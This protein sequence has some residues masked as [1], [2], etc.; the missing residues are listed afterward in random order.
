MNINQYLIV[1]RNLIFFCFTLLL[2]ITSCDKQEDFTPKIPTGENTACFYVDGVFNVPEGR[3]D[4]P[5]PSLKPIKFFGCEAPNKELAMV[6]HGITFNFSISLLDGFSTVGVFNLSQGNSICN[7]D[8]NGVYFESPDKNGIWG[9]YDSENNSGTINI[10]TM[11]AD[12]RKFTGSFQMDVYEDTGEVKHI[13]NGHFNINL[14][15]L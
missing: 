7:N 8:S 12:K 2:L 9:Y 13:T 4:F 14:D 11:S 10:E 1:M 3:S 6:L 5:Y 15:T